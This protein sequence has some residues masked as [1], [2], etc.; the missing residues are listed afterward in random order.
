MKV[1]ALAKSRFGAV[2][3][4]TQTA[5][6]ATTRGVQDASHWSGDYTYIVGQ[7]SSI[8]YALFSVVK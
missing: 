4:L 1:G 5:T 2:I 7:L 3:G 6:A 8:V